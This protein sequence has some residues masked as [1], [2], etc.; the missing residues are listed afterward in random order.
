MI[1]CKCIIKGEKINNFGILKKIKGR[2]ILR[3]KTIGR[4]EKIFR[5]K[6][7]FKEGINYA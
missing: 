2:G 6:K 1:H 4:A 5:S 7:F 3:R